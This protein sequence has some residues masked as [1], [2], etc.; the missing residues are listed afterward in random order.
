MIS[1]QADMQ[2]QR[3]GSRGKKQRV[4]MGCETIYRK[5]D[6]QNTESAQKGKKKKAKKQK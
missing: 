5:Y 4:K 3:Q 1:M 6:P 2:R